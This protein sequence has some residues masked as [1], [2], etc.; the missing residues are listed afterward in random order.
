MP[1]GLVG[2]G[3]LRDSVY[4]GD[5]A[6]RGMK[7][8]EERSER[9]DGGRESR[10]ASLCGSRRSGADTRGQKTNLNYFINKNKN[11]TYL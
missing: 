11:I 10:T 4:G 3:G 1:V 6:R 9:R 7:K 2:A 8:R 5:L